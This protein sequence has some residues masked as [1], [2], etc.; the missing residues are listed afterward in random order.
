LFIYNYLN[1]TKKTCFASITENEKNKALYYI[2]LQ[3]KYSK[4][5]QKNKETLC[6]IVKYL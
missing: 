4:E 6:V 5:K 1:H 2:A 3:Q